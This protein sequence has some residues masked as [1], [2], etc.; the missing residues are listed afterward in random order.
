MTEDKTK[1]QG[2][3][4]YKPEKEK[5]EISE[6]EKAVWGVRGKKYGIYLF[7][8][9]LAGWTLASYDYNLL[10]LAMP[11]VA[12]AL[13][14]SA[15]EV[16]VLGT[17]ISLMAIFVPMILGGLMDVYGRR[18]MWMIA[19]F[20]AAT[21]T[22]F[23]AIVQNFAELAIVRMLASSF[24]LSELGISITIVNESLGPKVRGWLYSW[25]QGGWPLGVFLASAVYL[26]FIG[27]GWR[28]V[29]LIGVIP[30]LLV[31]IGRYYIKD[32]VRFENLSKIKKLIKSGVPLEE[33]QKMVEYRV[34]L[35]EVKKSSIRQ[36]FATPGYVRSQLLKVMLAWFFYASSWMLTNVYISYFLSHYY[37]WNPSY[38][39]TLL[40]I[41][42]GIGFFFYPLGGFFGEKIG[43][44][45]VL[46]ITAALT[47]IFAAL[48]LLTVK[49]ILIASI[50]YFFL[51]QWTNGTWSGAGYAYWGESFPTRV[52]GTIMGFLTG[53]FNTSTF[54]GGLIFSILAALIVNPTWIWIILAVGLSAGELT[55]LLA[56]NIKPGQLL[57]DIAI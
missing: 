1:D 6:E 43:R 27:F 15:A 9:A 29:F 10:V 25:V 48:F 12:A 22:G 17:L 55:I 30:L 46:A 44:R 4:E 21:C 42:G 5:E 14:L 50:I 40:L 8:I 18:L 38:I 35:E 52:R 23:T 36:I 19:L 45:N 28:M 3:S 16:G 54:I 49:E 7:V 39:A 32:P 2:D 57:E 13:H 37:G 41:S 24:G 56:K 33:I 26:A 53:W 20:V 47:P 11:N 51:Y 34:D 31:A